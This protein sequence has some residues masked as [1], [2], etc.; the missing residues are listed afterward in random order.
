MEK[1]F[2]VVLVPK[3]GYDKSSFTKVFEASTKEDVVKR[4]TAM[5]RNAQIVDVQERIV[6]PDSF[7]MIESLQ[8]FNLSPDVPKRVIEKSR[9]LDILRR[10]KGRGK[11]KQELVKEN[12]IKKE[13]GD[14]YLCNECCKTFRSEDSKCLICN[15]QAQKVVQEQEEETKEEEVE[16]DDFDTK[17]RRSLGEEIEADTRKIVAKGIEDKNVADRI[18]GEKR[19]KVVT[20]ETDPK[21]FMVIVTESTDF[22]GYD[23]IAVEQIRDFR[24]RQ[25]YKKNYDQLSDQEKQQVD[26]DIKKTLGIEEANEDKYASIEDFS[27]KKREVIQELAAVQRQIKKIEAK[28]EPWT[29]KKSDLVPQVQAILEEAKAAGVRV[30]EVL[31]YIRQGSVKDP[32]YNALLEEAKRSETKQFV[33]KLEA[34]ATSLQKWQEGGLRI[35]TESKDGSGVIQKAK[36]LFKQI[37]STMSKILGKSKKKIKEA[38]ED[39]FYHVDVD[40]NVQFPRFQDKYEIEHSKTVHVVFTIELEYRSW[41]IKDA[42]LLVHKPISVPFEIIEMDENGDEMKRTAKEVKIDP[43][44]LEYET[45][46]GYGITVDA[47]DVTVNEE[48]AVE[49]AVVSVFKHL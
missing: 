49:A 21:K 44:D 1:V 32:T 17:K 38:I 34:L 33:V 48:G 46:D 43:S 30:N 16:D 40:L 18:A 28:L 2:D 31:M 12:A 27:K 41:G 13:K 11:I 25:L 9:R 24:G 36:G 22:K 37:T 14:L 5:Y 4:A 8:S 26:S 47:V 42:T 35:R 7:D 29:K 19:G 3:D 39:D 23:P 15:E 45:T 10:R 20:D 6:L